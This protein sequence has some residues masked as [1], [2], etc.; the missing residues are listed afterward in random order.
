MQVLTAAG[1]LSALLII[2]NPIMW[3]DTV[4][5]YRPWNIEQSYLLP[6][7]P[8]DW[9]PEGHLAYFMVDIVKELDLSA[10]IHAIDAK[11]D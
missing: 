11:D 1:A 9:L 7:S 8:A 10:I 2:M 3:S 4:K 5:T 6:P